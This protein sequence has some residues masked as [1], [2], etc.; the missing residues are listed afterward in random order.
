[1]QRTVITS[2]NGTTVIQQ[3]R[4]GPSGVVTSIRETQVA[5]EYHL[6]QAIIPNEWLA[7]VIPAMSNDQIQ[8]AFG[9]QLPEEILQILTQNFGQ[10]Q[11]V[12][13]APFK[14]LTQREIKT[15]PTRRFSKKYNPNSFKNITCC[16]CTDEYKSKEKLL[17]LPCNHEF[18]I[19][20]IS[21]WL[22]K[23]KASCPLCQ[24][25]L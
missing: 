9:F 10:Y 13:E 1:M 6:E 4:V 5:P 19:K 7:S 3:Q 21:T 11:P 12:N 24:L 20:C 8:E 16:I 2:Q 17:K 22:S 23:H 15:F 14:K 18:H 25:K